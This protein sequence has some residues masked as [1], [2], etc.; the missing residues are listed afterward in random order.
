MTLDDPDLLAAMRG[1]LRA[2]DSLAAATHDEDLI[3]LSEEKAVAGLL[4][5]KRLAQ[6][7]IPTGQRTTT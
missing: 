2:V 4:L 7:D 5:R 3:R 6:Q 1:Y